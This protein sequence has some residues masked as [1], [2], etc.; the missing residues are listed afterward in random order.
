MPGAPTFFEI[1]VPDAARA[2]TFYGGLLG[3]T[4]HTTAGQ[5]A[6]IETPT[7]RGGIHDGDE[8]RR[9]VLYFSVPDLDAAVAR[10][11]E[12]GGT[13]DDPGPAE[14]GFGRFASCRDDQGTPFGLHQPEA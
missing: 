12:L 6:W 2:R 3:W 1:G 9:I 10:L 8:D 11:R 14:P 4:F 5:Q 13:A 7:V